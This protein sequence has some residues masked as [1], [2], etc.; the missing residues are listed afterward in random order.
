MINERVRAAILSLSTVSANARKI[1]E[2]L[3]AETGTSLSAG[4]D[5]DDVQALKKEVEVLN[6][7]LSELRNYVSNYDDDEEDRVMSEEEQTHFKETFLLSLS[8]QPF[9]IPL[10]VYDEEYLSAYPRNIRFLICTAL[11]NWCTGRKFDPA[12]LWYNVMVNNGS[13]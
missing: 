8:D 5:S 9:V 11:V 12:P 4:I 10:Q 7:Q 1:A 6:T 3:G 13:M 2:R